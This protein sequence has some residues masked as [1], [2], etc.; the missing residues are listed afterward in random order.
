MHSYLFLLT[1]NFDDNG[2]NLSSRKFEALAEYY[3]IVQVLRLFTAAEEGR[4][5]DKKRF[6]KCH[7]LTDY[8]DDTSFNCSCFVIGLRDN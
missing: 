2:T 1:N 6:F 4:S 3:L 7:K 5:N 8:N